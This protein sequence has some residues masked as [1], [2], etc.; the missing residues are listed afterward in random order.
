MLSARNPVL[1]RQLL[2][3]FDALFSTT[4]CLIAF[5][6]MGASF[7]FDERAATLLLVSFPYFVLGCALGDAS[8]SDL[9]FKLCPS[10]FCFAGLLFTSGIA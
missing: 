6:C 7:G 4:N 2:T 9:D 8:M 3:N 1:M 5:V 10:G